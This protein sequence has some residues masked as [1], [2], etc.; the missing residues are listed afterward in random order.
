MDALR[1]DDLERARRT[2]PATKLQQALEAMATGIRLKRAS[3]RQ[4]H[5]TASDAELEAMLGAWLER[6]G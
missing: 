1:Q 3:L 5:P 6:R 2:P 4:R